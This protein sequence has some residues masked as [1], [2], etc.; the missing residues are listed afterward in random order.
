MIFILLAWL[1]PLIIT[2][3]LIFT[4]VEDEITVGE[5]LKMVGLCLIP[6]INYML[7]WIIVKDIF[8]NSDT[9]QEFLKKKL[10]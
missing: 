10:K 4:V 8:E 1:L 3:V 5:F 9:I 7:L 6:I 2:V